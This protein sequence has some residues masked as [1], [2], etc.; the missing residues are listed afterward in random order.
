MEGYRGVGIKVLE[1]D[2]ERT[3]IDD[4]HGEVAIPPLGFVIF[5]GRME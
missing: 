5:E 1:L 3:L 4:A 2:L